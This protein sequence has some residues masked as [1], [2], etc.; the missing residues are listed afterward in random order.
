MPYPKVLL[1]DDDDD[2][3]EMLGTVLTLHD[4]G[5]VSASNVAD[6]LALLPDEFDAIC[7]DLSMPG[8]D[9]FDFIRTVRTATAAIPIVVVSGLAPELAGRKSHELGCCRFLP[10]PCMPDELVQT[11]R[12][13]VENCRG[14]C[15]R[16]AL[17]MPLS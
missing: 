4:F 14:V 15:D 12:C 2:A 11:L 3:V 6:A 5:V 16:C 1:V 10:K 17:R 13:L 8:T 7:T 9:G